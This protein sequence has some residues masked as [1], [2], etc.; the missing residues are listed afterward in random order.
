MLRLIRK[1][2]WF[3]FRMLYA[4]RYRVRVVG[5][6]KLRELKG[7][8]LV[9]PNHCALVDPPMLEAYLHRWFPGLI[10]PIVES[11]SY[12]ILLLYP[13]MRLFRALEVPDP[14]RDRRE[15]VKQTRAMMDRLVDEINRGES[16][17]LYPSGHLQA[18]GKE[19][20]GTTRAAADILRRVE[21]VN[22]VLVRIRGLWGSRF[23]RVRTGHSP[24]LGKESIIAI[25]WLLAS[26]I[27][28]MPRRTVT[29]T[30]EVIPFDSLPELD[31]K[32]LNPWLESWYNA[33]LG[34]GLEK[35]TYV[36]YHHLFGPR[37][38]LSLHILIEYREP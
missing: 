15:A 25:G 21:R 4:C 12:R 36:P 6:E 2:A 28:F 33:D 31:R 24:P 20:I 22:V 16:F 11:V 1:I 23:G 3:V 5:G 7:A 37:G 34:G 30:V 17:L 8:V 9:M 10:R 14:T 35:P 18:S 38:F 26:L 19:V 32:T 29:L 27:V 13:L